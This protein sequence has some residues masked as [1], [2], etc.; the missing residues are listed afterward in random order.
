MGVRL[1]IW[2]AG[3]LGV[4]TAAISAGCEYSPGQVGKGLINMNKDDMSI[5]TQYRFGCNFA[6]H[7][8]I[9]LSEKICEVFIEK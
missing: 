4:N 5:K 8:I 1:G 9:C 6:A 2:S 3:Y 7:G